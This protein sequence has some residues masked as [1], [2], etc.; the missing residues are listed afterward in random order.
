MYIDLRTVKRQCS[1]NQSKGQWKFQT[2]AA[3]AYAVMSLITFVV[4]AFDKSA[5]KTQRWRTSEATLHMLALIGGWPGALLAQ[6]WLRHK[7]SKRVFRTVFWTMVV[8]NVAGVVML[9][10]PWMQLWLSGLSKISR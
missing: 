2:F 8:L 6:Q 4:Y 7:S 9:C 5:A 1:A 3:V 10:S